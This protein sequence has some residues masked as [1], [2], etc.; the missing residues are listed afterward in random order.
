MG[1]QAPRHRSTPQPALLQAVREQEPRVVLGRDGVGVGPSRHVAV[2]LGGGV[3]RHGAFLIGAA[4]LVQLAHR[5]ALVRSTRCRD[6]LGAWHH[7]R[8]RSGAHR[9]R[10]HRNLARRR[11]EAHAQAQVGRPQARGLGEAGAIGLD[12][13]EPGLDQVVLAV[14]E[15]PDEPVPVEVLRAIHERH[16]RAG[17]AAGSAPLHLVA[18]AL[19]AEVVAL[20]DRRPGG[21]V[22]GVLG[23][24]HPHQTRRVELGEGVGDGGARRRTVPAMRGPST[25]AVPATS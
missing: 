14:V 7:R 4:T 8:T 19:V 6:G 24:R 23:L 9:F 2:T 25:P 18:D 16:G 20:R 15:D 11:V 1:Q 12:V 10:A 21:A 5:L 13:P 17:L 22:R 3:G